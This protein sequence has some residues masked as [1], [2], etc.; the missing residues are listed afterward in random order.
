MNYTTEKFKICKIIRRTTRPS[1]NW[2]TCA[3][4]EMTGSFTQRY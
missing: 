1:M 4:S 2:K 3:V